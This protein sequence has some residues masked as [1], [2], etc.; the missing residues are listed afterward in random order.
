MNMFCTDVIIL[1]LI[2]SIISFNKPWLAIILQTY[3]GCC[4]G[5]VSFF[6]LFFFFLGL[7]LFLGMFFFWWL[8]I[9]ASLLKYSFR[10]LNQGFTALKD[11]KS[12]AETSKKHSIVDRINN[13]IAIMQMHLLIDSG[14]VMMRILTSFLFRRQS[15]TLRQDFKLSER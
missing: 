7:F 12:E 6:G 2:L 5:V 9:L 15:S 10:W 8:S 3:M 11:K 14:L 1:L 13:I 4:F